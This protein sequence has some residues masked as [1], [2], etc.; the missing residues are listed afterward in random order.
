[1]TKLY[2]LYDAQNDFALRC[3]GWLA[4]QPT[5]CPLEFV[6]FQALELMARFAGIDD[7]QRRGPLLVVSDEGGVYA[8]PSAF[9]ICLHALEDYQ[10]WAFRL[11][12]PMLLPLARSAFELL[13]TQGRKFSRVMEKLDDPKLFWLLQHQAS[14]SAPGQPMP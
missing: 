4:A 10:D 13:S 1:M 8:G 2:V 6:P 9:V 12:A 7:F 3:Y 11:S 14:A 5:V